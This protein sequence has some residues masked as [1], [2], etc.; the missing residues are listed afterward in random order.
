M[1]NHSSSESK[2]EPALYKYLQVNSVW[3]IATWLLAMW[4]SYF[5]S[6]KDESFNFSETL[7]FSGK[8]WAILAVISQTLTFFNRQNSISSDFTTSWMEMTEFAMGALLIG[9]SIILSVW[10]ILA[11]FGMNGLFIDRF[12]PLTPFVLLGWLALSRAYL[13]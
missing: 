3:L 6:E 8:L 13:T 5:L 10:G 2:K 7:E 9:T 4:I 12:I 11:I 1:K